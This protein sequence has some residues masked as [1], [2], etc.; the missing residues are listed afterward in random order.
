MRLQVDQH[1][2]SNQTAMVIGVQNMNVSNQTDLLTDYAVKNF[3]MLI[4]GKAAYDISI[5]GKRVFEFGTYNKPFLRVY[6]ENNQQFFRLR[7]AK[8]YV[9]C[10]KNGK[11]SL[12]YVA[13]S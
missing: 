9:K 6:Y 3:R 4:N 8:G 1:D 10:V 7:H 5:N 12:L 11:K 2:E 13:K